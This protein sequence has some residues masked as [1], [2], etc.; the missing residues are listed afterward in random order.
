MDADAALSSIAGG[1]VVD[2]TGIGGQYT[3][4]IEVSKEVSGLTPEVI[5]SLAS[6]GLKLRREDVTIQYVVVDNISKTAVE[7]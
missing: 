3:M 5:E 6:Y 2:K 4:W 7:E 1:P